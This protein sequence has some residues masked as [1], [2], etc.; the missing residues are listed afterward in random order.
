MSS[1]APMLTQTLTPKRVCLQTGPLPGGSEVDLYQ[2]SRV[3]SLYHGN[4][5]LVVGRT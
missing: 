5:P 3:S 4:L 1:L 2:T